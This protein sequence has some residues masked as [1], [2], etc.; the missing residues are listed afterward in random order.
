MEKINNKEVFS[1]E[2]GSKITQSKFEVDQ[3]KISKPTQHRR[4]RKNDPEMF[5]DDGSKITYSKFEVND[6]RMSKPT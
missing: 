5:S 2:G 1:D 3:S 6:T 4:Q